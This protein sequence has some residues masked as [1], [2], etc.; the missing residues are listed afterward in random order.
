MYTWITCMYI[1]ICLYTDVYTYVHSYT[2]IYVYIYI[3]M[4]NYIL[5]IPYVHIHTHVQIYI[6]IYVY[7]ICYIQICTYIYACCIQYV[8]LLLFVALSLYIYIISLCGVEYDVFCQC[9]RDTI[10]RARRELSNAIV[11]SD[12]R[13]TS[14]EILAFPFRIEF[15]NGSLGVLGLV[16]GALSGPWGVHGRIGC[17]PLGRCFYH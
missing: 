16:G 14:V 13:L 8:F 4:Y 10:C 6:Y 3:C 9:Q 11:N 1:Y 7:S 2:C 17:V 12:V 15:F 5:Y